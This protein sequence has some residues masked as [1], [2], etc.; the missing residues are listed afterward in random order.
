MK[1]SKRLAF[2]LFGFILLGLC[3]RPVRPTTLERMSIETM[4][5]VAPLIV[6]ARCT[7]NVVGW[8]AGE[9][10]TFTS[11]ETRENW[12]GQAPQQ[13]TVRLLGGS[14]GTLT[15]SVSGIP[16]FRPGE[17]VIL[18]LEPTSRGDFSIVSWEEGTFRIH[19]RDPRGNGQET[20]TQD[21]PTAAVFDPQSRR[22]VA[23]AV[24]NVPLSIFRSQV[25]SALRGAQEK[26]Q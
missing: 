26:N 7:S 24:R 6:R 25:E 21:V 5:H 20:V 10:W 13:I 8:D 4:S 23:N 1:M 3:C 17:E 14:V 9:I 11:F 16:H 2:R 19:S 12:K 18:F 15:S 22:F